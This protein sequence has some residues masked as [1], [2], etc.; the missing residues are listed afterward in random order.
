MIDSITQIQSE[1]ML[2]LLQMYIPLAVIFVAI[3]QHVIEWTT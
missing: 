3:N 1:P 2:Y